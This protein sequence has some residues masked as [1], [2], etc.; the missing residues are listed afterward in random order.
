MKALGLR[1]AA[2]PGFEW[3]PGMREGTAGALCVQ[4]VGTAIVWAVDGQLSQW[5]ELEGDEWPDLSHSGTVGWL[6][7]DVRVA[8]N[9][10]YATVQWCWEFDANHPGHV[11]ERGL[12]RRMWDVD[13]ITDWHKTPATS[14][15]EALITA[16][17]L[18]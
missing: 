7:S 16:R 8:H 11:A 4:V 12:P 6:R 1:W 2:V 10:P 17:E 3:Q 13:D 9:Q 14:E 18:A 5:T 15:V